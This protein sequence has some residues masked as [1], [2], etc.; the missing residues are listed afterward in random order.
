MSRYIKVPVN[1]SILRWFFPYLLLVFV[2]VSIILKI[3]DANPY[4]V[5]IAAVLAIIPVTHLIARATQDLSS[6]SS[7]I[8]G[9]LMNATFGNAIEFLIA[10]FA[11]RAGLID[12]VR[13]SIT[14]SIIINILLLI[15]LSM[16][17]GGIRFKEQTFNRDSAGMASTMLLIAVA[18]L[19]LPTLYTMITNKSVVIMSQ[20][21]SITLGITYLLS[22]FF[23]LFTHRHLFEARRD[24]REQVT[25]GW[26]RSVIVLLISVGI[27]AYESELLVSVLQPIFSTTGLRQ[28]FIGLVVIA[29]I[30]NVSEH[31]AAIRFGMRDN[32]TLSMEIGMNS[33]I[34]IALFVV[35]V[36]V[37]VAP[38]VGAGLT[39]AFP[40]FQMIAL[41]LAV[42]II[43]YMGSDGICNWLEGVQLVAVYILIAI[44]FYFL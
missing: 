15:G 33:A 38:L 3:V 41:I 10:I 28:D 36:L 24:V 35:P 20:A 5:S 44:A 34:Q 14:G 22:L 23:V 25:W 39:L 12:M 8:V 4:A 19:V 40:P 17:F 26:R 42:M 30:T 21:V 16:I 2:P 18:G 6:R 32:I 27:A 43:N 37:L 11:L 13:A 29:L 31:V 9:S 1:R 7:T